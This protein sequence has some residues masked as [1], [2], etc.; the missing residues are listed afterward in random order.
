[1]PGIF[2]H[3]KNNIHSYL[4][5]ITEI[6]QNV[7]H[8]QQI[9][10]YT[11]SQ[12]QISQLSLNLFKDNYINNDRLLIAIEGCCYNLEELNLLLFANNQSNMLLCW[13]VVIM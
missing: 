10:E 11:D 4:K 2:G 12:V 8:I 9:F 1:M 6:E 13:F 7:S 3:V 5:N